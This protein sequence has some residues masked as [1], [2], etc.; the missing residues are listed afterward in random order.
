MDNQTNYLFNNMSDFER[1]PKEVL[2]EITDSEFDKIINENQEPGNQVHNEPEIKGSPAKE[3]ADIDDTILNAV[4]D[5]NEKEIPLSELFDPAD[6]TELIDTVMTTGTGLAAKGL[7]LKCTESDLE[8]TPKQKKTIEK[9]VAKAMDYLKITKI[10]PI[11]L[12]VITLLV[13]YGVKLGKMYV[14]Q[15]LLNEA[16]EKGYQRGKAEAEKKTVNVDR[17]FK[18]SGG[19]REPLTRKPGERRG[20]KP[21]EI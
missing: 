18:P 16:E 5:Q 11:W 6:A 8:A 10:N 20:R 7:K 9:S 15:K 17:G 14:S 1:T 2:T 13:I 4:N 19:R 12:L 21:K 3:E